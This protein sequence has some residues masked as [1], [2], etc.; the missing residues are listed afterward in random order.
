MDRSAFAK[1]ERYS[2][3]FVLAACVICHFLYRLTGGKSPCRALLP[4][5]RKR[6]GARQ[7]AVFPVFAGG[8]RRVFAAASA[9]A[10]VLGGQKLCAAAGPGADDRLL[11]Y[12]HRDVRR[13]QP[14]GGYCQLLCMGARYVRRFPP[15]DAVR[16]PGARPGPFVL[17]RGGGA[18][19]AVFRV[20]LCA[21]RSA[22]V[23]C[24]LSR[25][26]HVRPMLGGW[27]YSLP[28]GWPFCF[29]PHLFPPKQAA[30]PAFLPR[31]ACFVPG[32]GRFHQSVFPPAG[33]GALWP[34]LPPC[35][36]A[37]KVG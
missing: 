10:A 11:L 5:Q 15:P 36:S 30:Y 37:Q 4:R 18:V 29:P 12:L 33:K 20:Y 32:K 23:P 19:R 34:G 1:A 26:R 31:M 6:M 21:A 3:L 2:A 28:R 25:R 8:M 14:M 13:T 16:R 27:A 7:A 17:C 24:R 22:A 9:S 35:F